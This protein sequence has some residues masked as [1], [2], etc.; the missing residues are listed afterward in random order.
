M[1]IVE[2]QCRNCSVRGVRVYEMRHVDDPVRGHLTAGEFGRDLPFVPQ[3]FFI[4]YGI[5]AAQ[6]RGEHAHLRCEQF[7]VCVHGRC[8]VQVDDGQHR[9]QI[10]LNHPSLGIYVPPMVW[11]A[12]FKHEPGSALMVFAS[13]PYEPEDYIR[14]YEEFLTLSVKHRPHNQQAS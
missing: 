5:P 13:R 4:T 14:G 9:E 2:T 6:I 12:E 3:R 1:K 8:C 10:T 7:L 11:A